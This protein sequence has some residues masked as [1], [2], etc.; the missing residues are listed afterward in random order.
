MWIDV[1]VCMWLQKMIC[2]SLKSRVPSGAGNQDNQGISLSLSLSLSPSLC[3][4]GTEVRGGHGVSWS[5]TLGFIP[6]RPD[7]SKKV[8]LGWLPGS[9][10]GSLVPCPLTEKGFWVHVRSFLAF[11]VGI[12]DLNSAL[13]GLRTI[14]SS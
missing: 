3:S 2:G 6:M 7:L 8:E 11:Y 4:Q 10:G 5:I 1:Y 14:M 9:L 13:Q 12:R